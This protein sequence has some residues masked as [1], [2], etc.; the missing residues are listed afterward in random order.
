MRVTIW[1]LLSLS[2]MLSIVLG[3]CNNPD[4]IFKEGYD[5]AKPPVEG[6]EKK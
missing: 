4:L 1:L 5:I 2:P 3:E 6:V